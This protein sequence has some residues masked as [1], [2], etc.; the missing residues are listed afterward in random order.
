MKN[1]FS[2][3]VVIPT[4]NRSNYLKKIIP[5]LSLKN[6]R[7][8]VI[9]CDSYSTDDTRNVVHELKKNYSYLNIKYYNVSKN[10]HSLKRNVGIKKS[11]GCYIV[12]IDD[13]C[14]P[15]KNFLEDYFYLMKNNKNNKVIFCGSVKYTNIS[16][17]KNFVKYRQ[18]RHFVL[19]K[20]KTTESPKALTPKHVVTMNMAFKKDLILENRI[21]FNENFNK[22]GFEDFEFAHRLI[23]KKIKIIPS[24]PA[25][26]HLDDR[27]FEKYLAKIKFL[28]HQSSVFLYRLNKEAALSNNFF[29]LENNFIFKYFLNNFIFNLIFCFLENFFV[30]IDKKFIYC[31]FIYKPAIAIA[32]MRGCI[33]RNNKEQSESY[34]NN[35]YK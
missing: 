18:S 19:E 33:L 13:D 11:S 29:K 34:T 8:E 26:Y 23:E 20:K 12:L 10:N 27:G 9:I 2:I 22:Y 35:W 14:I 28:G 3:S 15:E 4:Y 21:F 25:V 1:D 24:N 31:P 6:F 30:S 5:K 7:I 17:K 16:L 32:Y